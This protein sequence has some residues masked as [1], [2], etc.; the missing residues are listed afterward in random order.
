MRTTVS[1]IQATTKAYIAI[2]LCLAVGSTLVA[3][4]RETLPRPT[5]VL[6]TVVVGALMALAWLFPIHFAAKTKLYADAAVLIAAVL[7]LP[8]AFALVAVGSGTLLAHVARPDSRDWDQALFNTAQVMLVTLPAV[9]LL[10]IAGWDPSR[11]SFSNPKPLLII[12]VVALVIYL[13]NVFFLAVITALEAGLPIVSSFH[14]TLVED[15]RMEAVAHVSLVAT[16]VLASMVARTHPWG[17]ALLAVPVI[18]TYLTLQQQTRLRHEAERARVM[19]DAALGEAQRLAHLGSWEW[20]PS[21]DRWVWSDEVY[22]LFGLAPGSAFPT[23]RA[24]LDAAHPAD[25]ARVE[26]VLA[27]ARSRPASFEI[28]HRVQLPNGTERFVY[29]HAEAHQSNGDPPAFLGTIQDVTERVRTEAVMR[30]AKESAQEADRAKTKLLS[31][32][33]HELRTPLTA[34]QGYIEM[35]LGDPGGELSD[36][37]REFL[38]VAHRNTRRLA[39]LVNDFLDLARIEAGR[40]PLQVGVVEVDAAVMEVV[41]TLVPM[42]TEKGIPLKVAVNGRTGPVVLADP[43]RFNQVLL[44]LVDNAIKFTEKGSVT[45]S[46]NSRDGW[47]EIMVSDTGPGI[48]PESLPYVF[49]AFNQGRSGISRS[50]GAGLGLAIV[51]QLVELHGGTITVRSVVGK[52]TNFIFRLPAA[53]TEENR[54]Q[55]VAQP[56]RH[57]ISS[58]RSGRVDAA[59]PS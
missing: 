19:S 28:Q 33:S 40:L 51:K 35:V 18:A 52:G 46:A 38:E 55:D 1:K 21:T 56:E 4:S 2:L 15:L 24:L 5:H 50:E 39:G 11:S 32:A 57:D 36:E 23:C 53:L 3:L 34:I 22:R 42:A 10:A 44:N 7:L 20:R 16:G 14:A 58:D 31:M 48:P 29:Q 41:D 9:I 59:R 47:T 43:A 6:V 25:R 17:V 26:R 54:P 30:E 49:E 45:I 37:Q 8:P 12:P 13:L 27:E